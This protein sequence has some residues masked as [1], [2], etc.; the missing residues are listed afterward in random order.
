[1]KDLRTRGETVLVYDDVKYNL[2]L[3]EDIFTERFLRRP[4]MNYLR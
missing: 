2:S 4:P 1:M 3:P